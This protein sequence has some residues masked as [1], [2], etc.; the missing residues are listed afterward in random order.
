LAYG[1]WGLLL[2]VAALVPSVR[3][4][5]GQLLR[6]NR[7]A[8]RAENR[9]RFGQVI[10]RTLIL[11]GVTRKT[12]ADEMGYRD[13]SALSRWIAG[14]ENPQIDRLTL[15]PGFSKSFLIAYAETIQ[16]SAD[17]TDVRTVITVLH[18]KLE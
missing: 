4:R 2:P 7:A 9:R 14:T 18:K 1:V 6:T 8:E 15:I 17:V 5:I 12:A 11:A 10:E 13:H 3:P 16:D